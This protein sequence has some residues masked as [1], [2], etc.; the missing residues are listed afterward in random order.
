MRLEHF[1]IFYLLFQCHN[2]ST[3]AA[4]GNM[5]QALCT[6]KK[7]KYNK[8]T[9]YRGGKKVLIAQCDEVCKE[10]STVKAV[11]KSKHPKEEFRFEPLDLEKH[12]N[13]SLTQM[14]YKMAHNIF[15]SMLDSQMLEEGDKIKISDI[16][17][18]LWS[19][20]VEQ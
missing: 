15:K 16:F 4:A 19:L 8:C 14:G 2:Y 11:I 12:A 13:G 7:L 20:D 17:S 1:K 3:H 18:F 9:N 10:D 6:S 5:C